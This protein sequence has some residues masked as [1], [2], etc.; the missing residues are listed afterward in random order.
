MLYKAISLCY[1]SSMKIEVIDFKHQ[2]ENFIFQVKETD[3]EGVTNFKK[4][5]HPCYEIMYFDGGDVGF[6]V[7]DRQ[8]VMKKGDVLLIKPAQ[9]HFGN[10]IFESPYRRYCMIFTREM[11]AVAG[12]IEKIFSKGEKLTLGENS[13]F[14]TLVRSLHEKLEK[15]T[16]HDIEFCRSMLTAMLIAL[17]DANPTAETKLPSKITNYQK[18]INYINMHLNSINSVEDISAALFFSKS[19]IMHLFKSELQIG[20]MQYVRNKKIL[21]AHMEISK[22]RKPT[23]VYHECGFSNYPTFYR[24]YL[25]YFGFSPKNKSILMKD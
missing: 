23:D 21:L 20:V 4:H 9:Y 6:T 10:R 17:E 2:T 18:I 8:Y 1:S 15:S 19:Y 11:S 24:A 5:I 14:F 12:L 13:L 3:A 22:G 25:S 7:E 16:A